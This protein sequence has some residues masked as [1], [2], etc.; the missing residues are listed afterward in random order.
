MQTL[1][2]KRSISLSLWVMKMTPTPSRFSE[3]M[4]PPRMSISG[5]EREDV[6]SSMMMSLALY[7]SARAI[8]T[9]CFWATVRSFTKVRGLMDK[10]SLEHSSCALEYIAVLSRKA[11]FL[12]SSLPMKMLR[13]IS[14]FANRLSSWWIVTMPSLFESIGLWMSAS[15]PSTKIEPP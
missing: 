1:S 4:I 2:V 13:P 9:I 3:S 6:G 14:R 11:P 15:I 7:E 10:P 8:S 5:A 12:R